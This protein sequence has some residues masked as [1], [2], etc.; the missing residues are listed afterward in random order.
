MTE[1]S[2]KA[3]KKK[4]TYVASLKGLEKAELALR[5]L[6][7]ESKLNFAKSKLL[8]RSTVTKFFNREPIQLDSFKRIC[9][10]L[11]LN[12]Q[13]IAEASVTNE[14]IKQIEEKQT[15]PSSIIESEAE[16]VQTIAR[17]V[18]VIDEQNQEIKTAA[19]ILEGDFNSVQKDIL[20]WHN[21]LSKKY[22]GST[23]KVKTIK[24][25]SIKLII[26]GSQK[27]VE[28][29][30]ADFESGELTEIEGFPIED[31]QVLN[32]GAEDDE[33]SEQKWRLVEEIRSNS[34]ERRNL[35]GVDL[36]DADLIGA[37]LSDADLNRAK[38]SGADLSGADLFGADLLS[39]E[40]LSADLRGADLSGAD[41]LGAALNDADLSN[42]YLLNANLR[43]ANLSDAQVVRANLSY[44]N[45]LSGDLFGANL[46]ATDLS[47][48]NLL[49]ANLFGANLLG[50]DL[51][52]ANLLG[53]N[54]SYANLLGAVMYYP[55]S[56]VAANLS[57]ANLFGANLSGAD[58]RTASL[59]EAKLVDMY[60]QSASLQP[61]NLDHAKLSRLIKAVSG[62]EMVL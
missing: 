5:R 24:P 61:S 1:F 50:A 45:L 2:P 15:Q 44:A 49:G 12:W 36:S 33:S 4:I 57:G 26:E 9:E 34:V 42:A 18:T 53:A 62:Q 39:A 6:G 19:V 31:I 23:I 41:L 59:T 51:S 17:K 47:Y 11:T 32:E 21:H 54:L 58:L 10:A 20:I 56:L 48:A 40:L 28:M 38:L 52:Y 55:A 29:L 16:S 13:M 27:D 30:L 35:G 43:Y 46:L 8:S 3:R 14:N 7:L 25:G 37:D 22:P 60:L